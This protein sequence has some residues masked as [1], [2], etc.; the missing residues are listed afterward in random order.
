MNAH[1][2][3]G[4]LFLVLIFIGIPLAVLVL[5]EYRKGPFDR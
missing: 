3:V 2:I 5:L 4:V 1:I